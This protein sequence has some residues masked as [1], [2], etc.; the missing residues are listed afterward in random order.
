M[1]VNDMTSLSQH[2]RLALYAD[3]TVIIATSLKPKLLVS[4]MVSYIN[5][6]QR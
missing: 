4:Y 5:D 6:L 3:Y 2:V 1:Y